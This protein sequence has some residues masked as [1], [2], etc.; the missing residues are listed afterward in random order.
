M[1]DIDS[2]I[3]KR[4]AV[5]PA[6]Y[7]GGEVSDETIEE[8][9]ELAHTAPSHRLTLPWRWVVLKDAALK[10]LSD[11]F[12]NH[13]SLHNPGNYSPIKYKKKVEKPLKSSVVILICMRKDP[14][15]RIPEWEEVAATAMAVQN[16]WLGCTAR[17]LGCYWS[18]P[19]SLTHK[20][21]FIELSEGERCLGAFYIGTIEDLPQG[22]ERQPLADRIRWV[23]T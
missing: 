5:F 23:K 21:T 12:G 22:P 13:Y 14:E 18:S 1:M 8:L 6:Q 7:T 17:G 19:D 4:R 11:Y 3:K 9:L 2:I 15:G 10:R 16:M 20:N